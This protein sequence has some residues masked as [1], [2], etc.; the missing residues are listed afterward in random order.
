MGCKSLYESVK[1]SVVPS[2]PIQETKYSQQLQKIIRERASLFYLNCS[3]KEI[4]NNVEWLKKL[5][6][7]EIEYMETSYMLEDVSKNEKNNITTNII[8]EGKSSWI[9]YVTSNSNSID[10]SRHIIKNVF[11]SHNPMGIS[12][13]MVFYFNTIL[14]VPLSNLRDLGILKNDQNSQ[15]SSNTQH[16]NTEDIEPTM[17]TS[18]NTRNLQNFLQDAIKSRYSNSESNNINCSSIE[19]ITKTCTNEIQANHCDIIPGT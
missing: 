15:N 1:K 6:V 2:G 18:E 13:L 16:D 3:G 5:E 14:T 19:N 4:R 10:I 7:R 11:I 8:Q 9:L 17:I 12:Y